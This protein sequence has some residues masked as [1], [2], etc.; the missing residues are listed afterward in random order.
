MATRGTKKRASQCKCDD[1]THSGAHNSASVGQRV[2]TMRLTTMHPLWETYSVG[3]PRHAP[4]LVRTGA[5]NCL[6]RAALGSSSTRQ[7]HGFRPA[8]HARARIRARATFANVRLRT[9]GG[10]MAMQPTPREQVD[11]RTG[12]TTAAA[13]A[14]AVALAATG[15]TRRTR[16]MFTAPAAAP[17]AA[18]LPPPVC[19]ATNSPVRRRFAMNDAALHVGRGRGYACDTLPTI[20]ATHKHVRVPAQRAPRGA[21]RRKQD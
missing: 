7:G 5:P 11:T 3:H 6:A 13:A 20:S 4:S 14:A 8:S 12:G 19:I 10:G 18:A 2:R 21:H 9:Y 15:G 1:C 17:A 16:V